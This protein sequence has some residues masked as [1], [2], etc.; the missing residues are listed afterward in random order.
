MSQMDLA[1]KMGIWQTT[2]SAWETGRAIP[3]TDKLVELADVLG[4]SIDWLMGRTGAKRE[5]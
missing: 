3:I 1:M 4:V 5:M 2:V